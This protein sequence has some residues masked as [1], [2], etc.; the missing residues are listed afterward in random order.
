VIPSGTLSGRVVAGTAGGGIWT[1]DNGGTSW[2]ARTD[3]AADLAV[4][5][6]A[7]DPSNPNHLIAGTGEANQCGDCFAGDG[8]LVSTNAGTSWT[9]QNPG[10]AFAGI[11]VAQVAIDPSNSNHEF[12]A[13]NRGLYVTTNGG[14][15]WAKPTD[16]SY[17][18]VDGNISAV[19]VNPTTPSTIYIG[20]GGATV[21]KSTD[22]GVHWAAANTGISPPGGSPLIALGIAKSSPSTLYASVG[23]STGRVAL[24]KTSTG[25]SSWVLLTATPDYTGSAY[26]YG[27]GSGEQ[28]WYDNVVAVDPTNANHVLAGGIALVETTNGGTSWTNV[29]G[30]AFFGGGTNKIHPDQHALYFGSDGTVWIGDDGGV[31]HY[32]PSTLAVANANGN[33][34]VTQFY[35]GF[36]VA[37]NTL[38]AGAQDNASSRTS[39]TSAGPWTGIWVGDGGPSAITT[40]DTSVQFIEAD[41]SLY[42]TT[43]GFVGT[44]NNITP[45]AATGALFTPPDLVV[46]NTTTPSN[47]AVFYGATD[48]WR[49]TDP[50]AASPTWT[51]V[52]TTGAQVS[53]ITASANGQ[54]VYV[55]FTNGTI[56]VS[57]NGGATFTALKSQSLVETFVTGLSVNPANPKAVTVSFSYNDTRYIPGLPH[58]EQYVYTTSPGTGTWTTITGTGLPA[59][60][61]R[62]IYDNGALVAA[63]D[64]GV[65]ATGAPN[66]S[67]TVWSHL[68]SGLPNVQVQDLY[69][70]GTWLYAITH[71]RGA[72]KLPAAADLSVKKSGPSSFVK[73]SNGTYTVTVTNHGPASASA[74]TLTDGVPTGTT[75]VS[76]TQTAGSTF[77]CTNP[78][79]GGTGTTKCTIAALPS[80]ATATFSMTY[81][82]PS[83]TTLTSV[84]NTAKVSSKTPD[85][86]STNNSSTVTT[87]VSQG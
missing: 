39:S 28:G 29:N 87:P 42:V 79:A 6:V 46:P 14:T 53:A 10:G 34:N 12:A 11:D 7:V 83:S 52:T 80:G 86:T 41:R 37:G 38:L 85:P 21:A 67:S 43:D 48:L 50:T 1:S 17:A 59:A 44:L 31:Y 66:G 13:T 32:T 36:D 64:R 61:S 81:H 82:L 70:T 40:N 76:E 65:Y 68:G 54:V 20:G 5:A 57:T 33:L 27:S 3:S 71:G 56:E 47:P 60:V 58:V 62:V 19:V 15:S 69:L 74:V 9:L 18:A 25:G 55:G 24:Y 4:G 73:G 30:Q 75:F 8:I 72:W 23:S 49:T 2:T 84:S 78:A 45:P 77:T 51:K 22:G 63:T 26:S 16:S 35:F